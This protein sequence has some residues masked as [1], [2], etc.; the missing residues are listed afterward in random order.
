MRKTLYV[1]LVLLTM[2]TAGCT[3]KWDTSGEIDIDIDHVVIGKE[4]TP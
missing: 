3:A 2:L 4:Q 1:V